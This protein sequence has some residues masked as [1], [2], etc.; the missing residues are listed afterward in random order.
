[1]NPKIIFLILMKKQ[2]P[3]RGLK[4]EPASQV[5]AIFY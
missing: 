4:S 1:M 5:L 2:V 3:P